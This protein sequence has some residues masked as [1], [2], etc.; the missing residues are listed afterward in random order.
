MLLAKT[1]EPAL[2][3]P[4]ALLTAPEAPM[5]NLPQW[6]DPLASGRLL[7]NGPGA[8]GGMGAGNNGGVGSTDGPGFGPGPNPGPGGGHG[9][10]SAG[11]TAPKVLYQIDPEFSEEARRAKH[12][13][14]VI[15]VV[16]VDTT[17]H[18]AN[19]RITKSLGLGLDEKAVEAV[20][21]WRFQPGRKNGKPVIVPAT[22]EVNFHLL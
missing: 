4:P 13:G 5:A 12:Y 8:G 6:G 16:D 9:T 3:M 10:S 1:Q 20:L 21:R 18:A 22:I 2:L 14:T 19:V 17:G 15:L 11:I 7:S